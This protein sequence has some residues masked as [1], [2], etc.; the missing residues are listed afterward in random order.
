MAASMMGHSPLFE[1]MFMSPVRAHNSTILTHPIT[2]QPVCSGRSKFRKTEFGF[3]SV[4]V[5][6]RKS[7]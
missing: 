3:T 5:R 4:G 6:F 2:I 7:L 1:W